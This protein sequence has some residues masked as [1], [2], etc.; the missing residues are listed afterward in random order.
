MLSTDISD[1][2]ITFIDTGMDT[3]IGERLRRVRPYLEGDE[4]F[5]ANYGDV[6]TDAPMNELVDQFYDSGAVAQFIAVKPQ[7]SFHVV[8]TDDDD[9]VTDL[10]PA[11]N[12]PFRI[13]GGYFVL[14][15]GI[16]DYLDE[17][18][19]LVMDGFVKA[20]KDGKTL[21]ASYD[22]FWAAMDT[23]KER[24][25]LEDLHRR[26]CSPW[27]LWRSENGSGAP[28]ATGEMPLAVTP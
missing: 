22:G 21:A 13:N 20:A 10:V 5:L 28:P 12:L 26:G 27:A 19:D 23:L 4:Y 25:H 6:L 11:A 9:R 7:D 15:Q 1:W 3:P 8:E 17:G 18:D 2:T 14:R 24:A 16:F